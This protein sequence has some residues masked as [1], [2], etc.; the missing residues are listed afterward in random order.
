MAFEVKVDEKVVPLWLSVM[1]G[2]VSLLAVGLLSLYVYSFGTSFSG[3][4][5]VWGQFGDFFGG[6]LNPLC[7]SLALAALIVTMR[8]QS[9]E[10]KATQ[11]ENKLAN[12]H[13][14]QQ[15]GYLR[16]QNFE[17]VFFRLKEAFLDSRESLQ[18][19][20]MGRVLENGKP[21]IQKLVELNRPSLNILALGLKLGQDSNLKLNGFR[22]TFKMYSND[23]V[24]VYCRSLYQVLKY[25]DTYSGFDVSVEDPQEVV[26]SNA[27]YASV[28]ANKMLRA[29]R[30]IRRTE[31]KAYRP[32][33][34]SKRQYINMVRAQLGQAERKLLFMACLTVEGEG[35]KF[36]VEKY[37]LLKG[38][39][40]KDTLNE[41]AMTKAYSYLAFAD[42]EDIDVY[43]LMILDAN[44]ERVAQ[45]KSMQLPRVKA[46]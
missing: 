15:V 1:I 24:S 6:I 35:L 10:L 30:A 42:Y 39:E 32:A 22:N 44:R 37:S 36:F 25:V 13:L 2:A 38:V 46:A 17:A 28:P 12:A 8:L 26:A 21:A 40:F 45:K 43:H 27:I 19:E 41:E 14:E 11:A 23:S 16:V 7:S 18:A 29:K 3:K 20:H 31:A 4:Q 33:Y 5:E 9:A 34:H